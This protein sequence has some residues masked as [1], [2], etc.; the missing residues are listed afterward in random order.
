LFGYL[1]HMI[2]TEKNKEPYKVVR[3]TTS[4]NGLNETRH[5]ADYQTALTI[6]KKIVAIEYKKLGITP[7]RKLTKTQ[8]KRLGLTGNEPYI[9]ELSVE[10]EMKMVKKDGILRMWRFPKTG[11][12]IFISLGEHVELPA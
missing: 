7:K 8:V 3:H 10:E 11:T 5:I 9:K 6:A 12:S 2:K 1:C 4:N